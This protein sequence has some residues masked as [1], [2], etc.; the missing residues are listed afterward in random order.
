MKVNKSTQ[1]NNFSTKWQ[2]HLKKKILRNF[3]WRSASCHPLDSTTLCLCSKTVSI[4][5]NSWEEDGAT[6]ACLAH[7]AYWHWV[8]SKRR[9]SPAT[10]THSLCTTQHCVTFLAT[11]PTNRLQAL[12]ET[13]KGAWV[14]A[15]SCVVQPLSHLSPSR[16]VGKT[17]WG[18]LRVLRPW[19]TVGQPYCHPPASSMLA[20]SLVC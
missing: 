7:T 12:E 14:R 1:R 19:V 8:C 9:H 15:G 2:I 18:Q 5:S 3:S 17:P 11:K 4:K 20:V 10:C 13:R 6:K 16:G